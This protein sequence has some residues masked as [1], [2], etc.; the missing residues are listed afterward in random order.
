[1]KSLTDISQGFDR[2]KKTIL[3][4][5]YFYRTPPDDCFYL[6]TRPQYEKIKTLK[7]LRYEEVA[8]R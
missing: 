7:L 4:N 2:S 1:M 5:N 6:E 3:K 8:G